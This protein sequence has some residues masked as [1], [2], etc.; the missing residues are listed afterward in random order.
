MLGEGGIRRISS[1]Q[2]ASLPS[3]SC[4]IDWTCLDL[5]E[6]GDGAMA[7]LKVK[8]SPPDYGWIDMTIPPLTDDRSIH[9]SFVFDPFPGL[10]DWLEEIATGAQYSVWSV[11]EEGVLARFIF[12]GKTPFRFSE[13]KDNLVLCRSGSEG[14][15]RMGSI[16]VE[17]VEVVRQIYG[18]FRTMTARKNYNPRHWELH[19]RWH[20]IDQDDE[21]ACD[22]A[23]ADW[24][25]DGY[26][27]RTL[28]SHVVENFL[29]NA[30]QEDPQIELDF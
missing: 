17:R 28:R 19:P 24:P 25:F 13:E 7:K 27:L 3:T 10:I 4:K 2:H 8:F 14:I 11:D 5:G 15:I 1:R 6:Q 26:C 22:A 20:E 16:A 12:L 21:E 23:R 9:C 30:G 18:A 29:E